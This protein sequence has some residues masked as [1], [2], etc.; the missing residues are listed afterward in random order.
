[1]NARNVKQEKKA[2]QVIIMSTNGIDTKGMIGI[3]ELTSADLEQ[4]VGGKGTAT[5]APLLPAA[6]TLSSVT[7]GHILGIP[8]SPSLGVD[9]VLAH[10]LG[11]GDG[12]P[13]AGSGSSH[14][15][16][17]PVWSLFGGGHK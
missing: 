10:V 13:P 7:L 9:P 3:L 2:K 15:D 5:A 6:A 12:A 4:V 17:S 11:V 14:V 16:E 1:M 8:L